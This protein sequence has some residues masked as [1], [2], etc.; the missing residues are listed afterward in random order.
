MDVFL[1]ISWK[2]LVKLTSIQKTYIAFLK[3]LVNA[4]LEKKLSSLLSA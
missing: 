2:I 3:K 1:F 4:F